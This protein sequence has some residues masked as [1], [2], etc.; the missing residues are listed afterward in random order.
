MRLQLQH[1]PAARVLLSADLKSCTLAADC[2][3]ET[4][5]EREVLGTMRLPS[6]GSP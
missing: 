4:G 1:F 6:V 5:D 3:Q 2:A